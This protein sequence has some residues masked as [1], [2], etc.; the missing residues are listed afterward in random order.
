[1]AAG[2]DVTIA[3]RHTSGRWFDALIDDV[4]I[5]DRELTADEV[6][7]LATPPWAH[8]PSPEDGAVL[9]DTWVSLS[10]SASYDAVSHDVYVGTNFDDVNDG[11]GET[12]QGTQTTTSLVM[13]FAGLLYPD[14]L[15]LNTTYYWRVDEVLA[16]GT[17]QRGEVWSFFVPPRRAF[18]ASPADGA[19]YVH[20]NVTLS[21]A[22]GMNAVLHYVYF[23]NNFDDVNN[24]SNAPPTVDPTYT[25][26][27]LER[28]VEYYWRV[29][30]F[31]G[32]TTNKGDV[33]SFTTIPP[34][35]V[36]DPNLVGW[37]R[38]DE[39]MGRT[40]VDWSG[41]DRHGTLVESPQWVDGYDDGALEFTG[42]G[43][44]VNC[45]TAAAQEVTGDFT[46][47]AWARLAP[48]NA[49]HYGGIAGKLTS[50]DAEYFGFAIVR[51]SENDFR[52]WVADGGDTLMNSRVS[53]NVTY[54]DT[55]WHHVVGV[56]EGQ[57][58]ALY[59]D[60]IRQNETTTTDFVPSAEF[61]HIG[62]QYSHWD[63]R[64]FNGLIDDVRIYSRALTQEEIRLVMRINLQLAW[65]PSPA[66][67]SLAPMNVA[68]TL[69]WSAGDGAS[70]H[71]VYFGS[72]EA[73][74][75]AADASDTTGVY[76]GRQSTTSYVLPEGV[77]PNSGPF[78]WRVD[79][80]ANDGT[81]VAGRLWSFS[82]TDYALVE[83]FESY[84]DILA[85]EP[86]S[87]L[88]Y[89][90]W[91][92]GFDNPAT[93]GSTMGYPTG[94]SME[95]DTVHSG[96][97]S[98]PMG[99]NN[100]AVSISEVTRTFAAQNWTANGIQT[101]SL[102]FAGAGTNVPGQLYVK[103]NGVQVDY[104]GDAGNLALAGWQPWNIDLAS[105]DTNLSS[106]TSLLIGIRGPGATGTLILDDI[107]L[108]TQARELVT[109][110]QPDPASLVLHYAFEGN[111][112]DSAGANHGTA[113]GSPTYALGR[114]GQAI[115]LDGIDDYVA[116][117]NFS[118]ASR[119]HAEVSVCAWI[120]TSIEEDQIIASFDRDN[121]WR[122]EISGDG[123]GPGKVGWEVAT[124][125]G[126]VDYGS[127]ARV[128]DGLWHHVAGI[129]DN[130]TLTVYLDGNAEASAF[131]GP[132]FGTG[133]VR[134]G[135]VGLGSE[136]TSF[137]AD[138]RTPA[139]FFTGSVDDVRIYERALTH[140][141]I[142]GLAGRINP[143][144]KPF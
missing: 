66:N 6:M 29:D 43:Q 27:A 110:T 128:D 124:D 32:I 142:A 9:G 135:Y 88:V 68:S 41:Y 75:A 50:P 119:G 126:Q 117:D 94:A 23:G 143:F 69:N 108:Y 5:Y 45:G 7:A 31:D 122:L 14:G 76:R 11:T 38:L 134:Y 48:D 10:W 115:N 129:F 120:R 28:G 100:I 22:P 83:D 52:L 35:A 62:R 63:D 21:W 73:T 58:N 137:N 33:W 77:D 144:D 34:I 3:R 130:G 114:I 12:F 79:E 140:G 4:R 106:V 104:D 26:G 85:G 121:Y 96:R 99:Y 87:N 89:L 102:W 56:R 127:N 90:T 132:T 46:I 80:I 8:E 2:N 139:D 20:P 71:D 67:G 131:G 16:D 59:V 25:P 18:N 64:Y 112:N 125:T 53:S 82:V 111:A 44:Y 65:L 109:P 133:A 103:V 30:E 49:G 60:G 40:A 81:I 13:G 141:E 93:N 84:N 72:D 107:R 15:A 54:T 19:K 123:T 47:A 92:D 17:K 98:A 42:T 116:I 97:Q 95:T 55:A 105:I 57:T 39:G 138:P 24:A 37:W 78:Y 74:T 136:S 1:M 101:L 86:G 51:H 36:G 118:Y 61:A 70:Q 113:F 91:K